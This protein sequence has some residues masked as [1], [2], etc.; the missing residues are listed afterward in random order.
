MIEDGAQH[1]RHQKGFA[2]LFARNAFEH[3]QRVEAGQHDL[4]AL[5]QRDLQN[6]PDTRDMKERRGMQGHDA[7]APAVGQDR[8]E[9]TAVE[10]GVAEHHALGGAGGAAGIENGRKIVVAAHRVLDRRRRGHEFAII[11]HAVRAVVLADVDDRVY[12]VRLRANRFD[13]RQEG[14]V[15]EQDAC[16]AV[17]Q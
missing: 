14:I 9:R 15:D 4:G 2:D 16:T 8:A 7:I 17:V 12:R 10:V 5:T 11:E 1:G 13:H 3:G 6:Q